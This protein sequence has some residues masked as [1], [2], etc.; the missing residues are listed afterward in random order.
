MSDLLELLV[1]S[2]ASGCLYG[3]VALAYQ[4]VL[5]PTGV[6][7]F[8]SGEWAMMGAFAAYLLASV[9]GLPSIVA[10]PGAAL[11]LAAIGWATEWLTVRPLVER[12]ASHLAP[13]LAL[14][15]MLVVYHQSM[16]LIFGADQYV[17][18]GPFGF[19]RIEL[20]PLAG[21]SQSFFIIVLTVA[22]FV[23]VWL[24]FE[25]TVWGKSFEAVAINRRAAALMGINLRRVTALSFAGGAAVAAMAGLLDGPRGSIEV[26][27]ALP[28]AVQGFSALIIGGINRV[29]GAL[30]GGI[31]LA[32]A[33]DLT[34]RYVPIPSG[35]A[36]GVTPVLLIAFL[37]VRPTG[38]LRAKEA[39]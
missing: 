21:T 19:N 34:R 25:R 4:L 10:I 30:L 38:L 13:I 11:A 24:F 9:L 35:L 37:L 2:I 5:R 22:I 16:L 20:G 3:L 31:I 7:N 36:Q 26:N 6:V 17:L 8:A 39:G 28:Y 1:A 14:L 23:A 29:E 27:T 32:V 18:D 12:G 33:E 15:G